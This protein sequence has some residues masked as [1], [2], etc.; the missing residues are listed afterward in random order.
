MFNFSFEN[1][2]GLNNN[3]RN[4]NIDNNK[5]Y[6][7]LNISKNANKKDITKAF[8][9]LAMKH[10]PD[11][12]GNEEEFKKY[13]KAYEVLSDDEKRKIYDEHGEEGLDSGISEMPS[14]IFSFFNGNFNN[15]SNRKKHKKKGK[16]QIFNI[17]F[18]LEEIYNGC[19]K[20]IKL[21]KTIVKGKLKKCNSCNGKGII[22]ELR[23]IGSMQI[24]QQRTCPHC[25][26]NC[27]K[28]INET[29][30]KEIKKLEI[31]IDKGIEDKKKIVFHEEG[32]IY[33]GQTP[34][35]III[36]INIK[37]HEIFKRINNNLLIEKTISLGEALI[38]VNFN[39]KHL[40]NRIINISSKKIIF[41]NS[42]Q[43]ISNLGMP[44]KDKFNEYG[45]L[46]INY[47]ILFPTS[48]SDESK[49]KIKDLLPNNHADIF[50]IY[51]NKNI[52][53]FFK[54]ESLKSKR[55]IKNLLRE[56]EKVYEDVRNSASECRQM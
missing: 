22:L 39:L 33:P 11:R 52:D 7:L 5:F 50:S 34:G 31:F 56:N 55:K 15:N 18:T 30:E 16:N 4:K 2:F 26:G 47:K 35:D 21:Q 40:D 9:K 29:R 19:K 43:L 42:F 49:N 45:N 28:I 32:D 51:K 44:I 24:Q 36:Q 3:R 12:G 8:R 17:K 25:K 23:R 41:P 10:H 48:L 46:L 27:E 6:N 14:D 54:G 13:Q 38:G 53:E 37:E 1:E 20:N